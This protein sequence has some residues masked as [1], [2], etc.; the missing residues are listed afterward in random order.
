MGMWG[1]HECLWGAC[2]VCNGASSCQGRSFGQGEGGGEVSDEDEK[3]NTMEPVEQ[4]IMCSEH[5]HLLLN[6]AIFNV[7]RDLAKL[8]LCDHVT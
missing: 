1:A 3:E 4:T 8:F 7:A 2:S 5:E 6:A